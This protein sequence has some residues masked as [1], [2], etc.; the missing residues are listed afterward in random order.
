[1]EKINSVNFWSIETH[2]PN[3]ILDG[4]EWILEVL[5]DGKY[6]FVTRNS[7]EIYGGQEYAELCK[8]I[9]NTNKQ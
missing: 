1:L 7:P 6:H 3:M 4:E 9:M 2:D 5:I 8:L